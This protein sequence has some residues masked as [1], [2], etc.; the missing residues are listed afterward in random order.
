MSEELRFKP[1]PNHK[2][3][4]DLAV[5]KRIA[6]IVLGTDEV[7]EQEQTLANLQPKIARAARAVA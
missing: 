2:E 5:V 1:N 3:G 6:Q 4:D 7:F